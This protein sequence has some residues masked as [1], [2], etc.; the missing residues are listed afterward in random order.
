MKLNRLVLA[1]AV[2][3]AANCAPHTDETIREYFDDVGI[4]GQVKAAIAG[5]GALSYL[6]ISVETF[7]G[8]V[9]LSG[10]V[11]SEHQKQ[12]AIEVTKAV[13]GV[14]DVRHLLVVK[15]LEKP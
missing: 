8:I 14:R 5:E 4:T 15:Y 10:F 6:S 9:L 13:P 12:Q 1:V 2:L 3:V 11:D 7:R